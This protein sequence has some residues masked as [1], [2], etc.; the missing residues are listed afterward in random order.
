MERLKVLIIDDCEEDAFLL[1]HEILKGGFEPEWKQ[2]DSARGMI[3]AL[4]REKWDIVLTDYSMPSFDGMKA[5]DIISRGNYDVPVIMISGKMGEENAVDAMLAGAEDYIIK[6]SYARLIPA[7]K[8]SLEKFRLIR[9]K[10]QVEWDLKESEEKFRTFMETARDLM[11]ITDAEGRFTYVN[12]SMSRSLGYSKEELQRM[13]MIRIVPPADADGLARRLETLRSQRQLTLEQPWVTKQGREILGDLKMVSIFA[14]E[15]FLGSRGIFH[16][17]TERKQAE[18]ALREEKERAE[19]ANRVKGEFLANMSHELLTPM[20]AIIGISRAL[21]KRREGPE[22]E[23]LETIFAS[24]NRLLAM[25]RDVLTLSEIESERKKPSLSRFRLL[26]FIAGIEEDMGGL[27]VNKDIVFRLDKRQPLPVLML[28]DRD[29]LHQALLNVLDNA[30]K[31]TEKGEVTL[32][33]SS[34]DSSVLFEVRDTGIGIS[35]ENV[36]V[37]F[38]R[39]RQIDGSSS[40]KYGGMG[41]GLYLAKK[42]I[43]LLGG[44]IEVKSEPRKGSL[45]SVTVPVTDAEDG[46]DAISG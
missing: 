23:G 26:D 41:I 7:I 10:R 22:G 37:I 12:E 34:R 3:E 15:E 14:A 18:K 29:M 16:D 13:S 6:G 35:A 9:E 43:E 44:R 5:L 42:S 21:L 17:I 40:R 20:N 25:I 4:E 8:R 45:F 1:A 46:R 33:V 2:A 19:A 28:S 39:F 11:F 32:G 38:D 36:G 30:V 31:F 27:I 24:G